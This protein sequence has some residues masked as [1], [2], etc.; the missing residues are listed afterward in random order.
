MFQLLF[1]LGFP[2]QYNF[3]I[4]INLNPHTH[5]NTRMFQYYHSFLPILIIT[6]ANSVFQPWDRKPMWGHLE[7]ILA[8]DFFFL[9]TNKTF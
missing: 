6:N 5:R 7:I 4:Y 1:S 3:N 9:I 2:L 8:I